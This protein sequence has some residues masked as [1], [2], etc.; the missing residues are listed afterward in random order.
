MRDLFQRIISQCAGIKNQSILDIKIITQ[1]M[2]GINNNITIEVN[3][4]AS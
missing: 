1:I 4:V 2:C 3:P